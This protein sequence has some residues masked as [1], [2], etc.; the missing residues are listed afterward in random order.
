MREFDGDGPRGEGA[1]VVWAGLESGPALVIVDPAG[2]AKHEVPPTWR[3]L[4]A[5]FQVAW[6]RTPASSLDE[7]EDVLESL[8]ERQVST[9]LVASG[10]ACRA[11]I[12]MAGQFAD[13][14]SSVLLVDPMDD[15]TGSLAGTDIEVRVVA[16]SH[17]GPT[18]RV[19]PP[20]PL[21]HPEVVEGV[22]AALAGMS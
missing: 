4:A 3:P 14:V 18:D 13:T 8:S 12:A 11:A 15:D 17:A 6:C 1:A 16:R 9:T 22:V 21:G 5:H 20:M 19:D 10:E 2:A 7:L